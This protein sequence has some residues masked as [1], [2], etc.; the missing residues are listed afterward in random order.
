LGTKKGRGKNSAGAT[1]WEIGKR[2]VSK[3]RNIVRS[4]KTGDGEDGK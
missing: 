4:G 2:G 1:T 3:L